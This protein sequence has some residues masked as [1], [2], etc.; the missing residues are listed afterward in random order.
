MKGFLTNHYFDLSV[1]FMRISAASILLF[2]HGWPKVASFGERFHNFADPI[3]LGG[4]LSFILIVFAEFVCTILIILGFLTRFAAIPVVIA[5][6]VIAFVVHTNDPWARQELPLL[7]A[8]LFFSI[9]IAGPGRYS[10]DRL[11]FRHRKI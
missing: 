4:E 11:I 7:F 6:S 1:L 2:F 9:L 3:G 5:M 10:L 8:I